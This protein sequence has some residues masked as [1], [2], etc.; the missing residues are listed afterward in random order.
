MDKDIIIYQIISEAEKEANKM[1][2]EANTQI[3]KDAQENVELLNEN[4][5]K[6][7][8]EVNK[9]AKDIKENAISMAEL[10]ARN[11]ILAQKQKVIQET[12]KKIMD[13]LTGLD[14]KEYVDLVMRNFKKI[15][16]YGI[17]RSRNLVTTKTKSRSYN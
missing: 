4:K 11:M 9:K 6:R 1:I 14:G 5:E 16:T 3:E 12:K 2:D 10:K 8:R 17:R 13:I 7:L 15:W